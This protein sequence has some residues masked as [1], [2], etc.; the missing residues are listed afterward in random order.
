MYIG[1]LKVL[2]D[3]GDGDLHVLAA[4]GARADDLSAPEDQ[5]GGLG[6]LESVDE[7]GEL[8]GVVL[9][10]LQ[11]VFNLVQV[12][13][14]TKVC[15]GYHVLNVHFG[16]LFTEGG[17]LNSIYKGFHRNDSWMT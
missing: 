14:L 4:F 13:F 9:G 11:S 17:Y 10:T 16:H 3:L 8:L 5:G 7:T 12:E 1:L 15:R 2:G 6:L